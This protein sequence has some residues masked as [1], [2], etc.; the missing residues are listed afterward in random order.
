MKLKFRSSKYNKV[1][2]KLINHLKFVKKLNKAQL[3]KTQKATQTK[4]C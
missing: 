2:I 3:N 1:Y 4:S